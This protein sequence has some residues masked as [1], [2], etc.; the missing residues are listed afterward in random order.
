[1]RVAGEIPRAGEPVSQPFV[2]E[3]FDTIQGEGR[4]MGQPATFLRLSNCNLQCTWCDTPYT[5]NWEGTPY[6]HED[7]DKYI[8]QD[9]QA[10]LDVETIVTELLTH[11][12]KRLVIS[13]GEPMIQQKGI[14][15]LVGLLKTADPE[16]QVEIET[17]GT[18]PPSAELAGLVDQFNV[19]PKLENS[20]NKK[21]K[22]DKPKAMETFVQLPNADFKFV[23][24]SPDDI[25]EV[26]ELV[27][28]YEIPANRVFLMPEGRTKEKIEEG[29]K[30]L[31]EFCEKY[32]FNLSTRLHLILFGNKRGT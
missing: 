22:R 3:I 32:G 7:G 8:R 20:G 28:R 31:V 16:R 30:D 17:N 26:L 14:Y 15:E 18:I 1:M 19:S 10:N 13:G 12:I 11:D 2:P 25:E 4:N 29:Q 9:E 27:D 21:D 23:L 24:G 6:E 5:W